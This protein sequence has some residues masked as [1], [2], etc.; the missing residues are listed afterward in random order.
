MH[1]MTQRQLKMLFDVLQSSE[2]SGYLSFFKDEM[3]IKITISKQ[4][5]AC[6][7]Q[8]T[9]L[10]CFWSVKYHTSAFSWPGKGSRAF[11]GQEKCD[12]FTPKTHSCSLIIG[13]LLQS[14]A[15]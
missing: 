6:D 15:S 11:P 7:K 8:K 1:P 3:A 4:M 12:I 13:S 9:A 14:E 2:E 5:V 10:V